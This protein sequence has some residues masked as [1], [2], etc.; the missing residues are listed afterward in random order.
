M[1]PISSLQSAPEISL[2]VPIFEEDNFLPKIAG[3]IAKSDHLEI[4]RA[5][6]GGSIIVAKEIEYRRSGD[7]DLVRSSTHLDASREHFHVVRRYSTAVAGG[8]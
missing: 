4:Y 2:C 6:S 1:F 7:D 8:C 5:L 3:T